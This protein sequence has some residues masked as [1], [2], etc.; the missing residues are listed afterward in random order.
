MPSTR[1]GMLL[2]LAAGLLVAGGVRWGLGSGAAGEIEFGP[3]D[4]HDLPAIDVE[5]LSVGDFAPD[6]TLDS[7]LGEV[8]TLS[9]YRHEKNVLLVFYR[10]H[11]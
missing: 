1:A 7:F 6:F 10:G 3:H 8:I 4:G 9:D 5:R 2:V 11:W